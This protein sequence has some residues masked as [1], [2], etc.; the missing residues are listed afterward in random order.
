MFFNLDLT[1]YARKRDQRVALELEAQGVTV[2]TFDDMTIHHPEEIVTLTGRPYQVFTAF[3]R[4][5]LAL[6]KPAA[7][8][9]ESLP[10]QM[11][12][13]VEAASLPIDFEESR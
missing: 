10:E 6:P 2:E 13:S 9:A 1:P 4:A 5:W 11:P 3:K 8:E 12:L 7:D